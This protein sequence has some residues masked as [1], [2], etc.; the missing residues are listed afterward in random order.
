MRTTARGDGGA[1]PARWAL[2]GAAVAGGLGFVVGVIVGLVVYAPTALFAGVE[3]GIPAAVL[4]ALLGLA[5][6]AIV[7]GRR[8]RSYSSSSSKSS[9]RRSAGSAA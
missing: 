5:A 1:L 4:G 3:L 6:G 8:A 9:I 2:I 7:R